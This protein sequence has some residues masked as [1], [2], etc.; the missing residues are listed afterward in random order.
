MSGSRHHTTQSQ[1]AYEPPNEGVAR[2]WL[3]VI[4]G[5]LLTA[6]ACLTVRPVCLPDVAGVVESGFGVRHEKHGAAWYHC[7]PWIRRALAD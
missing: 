3:L 5:L 2:R 7:E 1:P 4:A 6:G